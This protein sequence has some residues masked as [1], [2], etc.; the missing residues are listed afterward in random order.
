MINSPLAMKGC[1]WHFTQW[2][3]HPFIVK[4]DI[5]IINTYSLVSLGI[6]ESADAFK[7]ASRFSDK[8]L[9]NT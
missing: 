7:L 4:G 6:P 8:S 2:Q 9:Y 1:I 5:T 3:I